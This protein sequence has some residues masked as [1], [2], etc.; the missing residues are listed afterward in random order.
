MNIYQEIWHA[1]M[2]NN[3]IPPILTTENG[4][5][6]EG[7]VIVDIEGNNS[8]H[9]IL[10]EVVIPPKKTLSY[11][12]VERL[13]DNYSLNQKHKEKNTLAESKEVEDFLIM[14]V[15]SNPLKIAKNFIEEK[16]NKKFNHIEWYSYLHDLWFRQFNWDKGRDLSA[17]EHIFIGEQKKRKL[18]GHHFWYKYWLEDNA[19][20][21]K[22]N[23]DQIELICR[24]TY[25]QNEASPYAVTVGCIL[26]AFDCK[27]RRFIE[28]LKNRCA[29]FV[30][31]SAEGLLALGTVRATEHRDVPENFVINNRNYKLVLFM[32]PD[33]KSI[34]TFY[35]IYIPS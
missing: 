31:I 23:I 20:I 8:E 3:G 35:P 14:A 24:S 19:S 32:S 28:I 15:N 5:I 4:D 22:H 16:L 26:N 17:F 25:N 6:S 27:K 10:K 11:Q 12:L 29:F 18:L 13:F 21:N 1:D 2:K 9:H 30:G 7:Y 33:G 34:R